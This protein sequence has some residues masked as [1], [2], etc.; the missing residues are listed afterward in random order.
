MKFTPEHGTITLSAKQRLGPGGTLD[1]SD[2]VELAVSDTGIGIAPE[3][4]AAIFEPF[5][6]LASGD[7]KDFGGIG[8]GL[9]LV[10]RLTD[11]LG[12]K[13]ELDS[14]VGK[15]STFRVLVP[16]AY[17]G[18]RSTKMMRAITAPVGIDVPPG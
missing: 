5:R 17:R 4:R 7:N 8:L 11:L 13:V 1:D 3:Q 10:A 12:A 6:Q 16:V 14:T 18:K 9:A 2:T 15:G